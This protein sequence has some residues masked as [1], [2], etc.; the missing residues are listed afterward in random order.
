MNAV[1]ADD[2]FTDSGDTGDDLDEDDGAGVEDALDAAPAPSA[3]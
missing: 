3:V 1:F 2:I